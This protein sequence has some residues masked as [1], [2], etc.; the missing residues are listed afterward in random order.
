LASEEEWPHHAD[1]LKN[2]NR[3]REIGVSAWLM[4]QKDLWK[5][6]NCQDRTFWYQERC[7]KCKEDL[8]AM[9]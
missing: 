4:E 3:M 8:P 1:V 2:L 6:P 5:C 9:F 7:T